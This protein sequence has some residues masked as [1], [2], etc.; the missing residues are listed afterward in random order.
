MSIVV[1]LVL[2][3]VLVCVASLITIPRKPPQDITVRHVKSVHSSE[4]TTM[5]FEIKNHTESPYIFLPFEVQVRNGNAWTRFQVFNSGSIHPIP[6]VG[7]TGLA[8]YTVDVTNLPAKSVVRLSIHPQKVLLG[9][10]GLVRRAE[11]NIKKQRGGGGGRLPL[12]PYDKNSEVYG[13][14]TEVVSEEFVETASP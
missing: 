13:L 9:V 12:N 10:P 11:L 6:T 8:S 4:I 7:P 5:T 14:P 3:A 1:G 2:V